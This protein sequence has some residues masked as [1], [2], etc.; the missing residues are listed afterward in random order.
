M[1]KNIFKV[2]Q[3]IQPLSII[4]AI[5]L[6]LA[7]SCDGFCQSTI[8]I[9][10]ENHSQSI[11]PWSNYFYNSGTQMIY[12]ASELNLPNGGYIRKLGF[13]TENTGAAPI[14]S[15]L[16]Y[17]KHTNQTYM[18]EQLANDSDYTLVYKGNFP[19]V[20][21]GWNDVVLK[22]RFYYNGT[23]NLQIM[24]VKYINPDQSYDNAYFRSSY[25]GNTWNTYKTTYFM[26][27]NHTWQEW[28][29]QFYSYRPNIQ[30]ETVSDTSCLDPT[31]LSTTIIDETQVNLG[32]Q[33]G[34]NET[35]WNLRYKK[36][37]DPSFTTIPN[38]NT[39]SY[40]LST[41]DPASTYIWNVQAV[42]SSTPGTWSVDQVFSTNTDK[43]ESHSLMEVFIY[44]VKDKIY[45]NN[46]SN[47]MINSMDV[48]DLMGRKVANYAINSRDNQTINTSLIQGCYVIKISSSQNVS[49]FKLWL[50]Q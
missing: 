14:D 35:L 27:D 43:I 36:S 28:G 3:M 45:I 50:G 39:N 25:T 11:V 18:T 26:S 21:T 24:T 38:I 33:S 5:G 4:L 49:L 31:H 37:S 16:I 10:T 2:K 12:L 47:V 9:E 29:F 41:I 23:Q 15:V 40:L 34:G 17:M 22:P 6:F 1:I 13:Y 42:C 8:T 32:W 44:S 20:H 19:N 7:S 48:Y 30:L 46:Q